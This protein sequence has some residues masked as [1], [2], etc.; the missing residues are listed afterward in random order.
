MFAFACGAHYHRLAANWAAWRGGDRIRPI[1]PIRRIRPIFLLLTALRQSRRSQLLSVTTASH[2]AALERYD[3]LVEQVVRLVDKADHSVG[4]DRRISSIEPA[5]V[6]FPV[7]RRIRPIGLIGQTSSHAD[8][9]HGARLRVIFAPLHG[10]RAVVENLRSRATARRDSLVRR[11]PSAIPSDW[12]SPRLCCLRR[13][14]AG[15]CARPGPSDRGCANA[16]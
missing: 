12:R 14:F 9:A 16:C 6:F 8:R 2:K 10:D 15:R 11:S 3:L 1:G 13:C 7:I 5:R 4:D